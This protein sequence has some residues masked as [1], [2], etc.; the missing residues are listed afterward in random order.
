MRW[1]IFADAGRRLWLLACWACLALIVL[2][3]AGM[4]GRAAAFDVPPAISLDGFHDG[5]HHWR[6]I[7]D[8]SRVIQPLP[9]QASHSPAETG[10]MAENILLFQRDNG[11]W[12]KDYDMAA[13][14]TD[15]QK[16]A[17]RATRHREDTSF[18]NGNIHSQVAYLARAYTLRPEPAW[19]AAC[20]RGFDFI[21]A[22]QYASG[23]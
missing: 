12:P 15:A 10:S 18:D 20:E 23:R 16:E 7:R 3:P 17:L 4:L 6:N 13:V 9:G 21:L 5:A 1:R 8:D 19:H 11:G 22:A 2:A 14:L